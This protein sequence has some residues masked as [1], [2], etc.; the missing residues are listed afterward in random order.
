MDRQQIM[1]H[2]LEA[3]ER[4]DYKPQPPAWFGRLAALE[5]ASEREVREAVAQLEQRGGVVLTKRGRLQTPRQAGYV[6]GRFEGSGRG[7]GFVEGGGATLFVAARDRADALHGDLVLCRPTGEASGGRAAEGE[8]LRILERGPRQLLG[9]YAKEQGK[10]WFTP[11]EQRYGLDFAVLDNGGATPGDKVWFEVERWP[12]DRQPPAGAV[13]EV[14]GPAGEFDVNYR[15]LLLSHG[16][17]TEFPPAVLQRAQELEARGIPA[18]ELEGRRDLRGL[19]TFTIDGAGAKDFDDALSLEALPEGGF[20]LGVHIADVAHYVREGDPID[21]EARRRGTSVYFTDQVVPML[22]EVLSNQLCSLQPG[23]DRLT[24]SCLM[25]LDAQGN[26]TDYELVG[27]VIRSGA[28][29]IYGELNLLLEG[30][31]TAELAEKYRPVLE[32]ISTLSELCKKMTARRV[33][34][35]ALTFEVIEPQ[36]IVDPEGEPIDILAQPRGVTEHLVEE[37]MLAANRVVAGH[38]QRHRLPGIYRVHAAPPPD[39]LADLKVALEGFGLTLAV[40]EGKVAPEEL[41]RICREIEGS[42]H[43]QAVLGLM[44]RAMSKAAYREKNLGHYG[45]AEE[46]YCHFTSPIRRYPDLIVH[47]V[48]SLAERGDGRAI[49]R[50]AGRA[51]ELAT[52]AFA[53][54]ERAVRAERDIEDMYKCRYMAKFLG[55]TFEGVVTGVTGFGLFVTLKNTVEGLLHISALEDDDYAFD[56]QRRVLNGRRRGRSYR[57]GMPLS[58]TLVKSDPVSRRIDFILGGQGIANGARQA[59]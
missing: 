44:I 21:V 26:L 41:Q 27:S 53:C 8:V 17:V 13:R 7:F 40:R 55:E 12:K 22:P 43:E 23:E 42:P 11:D 20:V 38:L 39:K 24:R 31:A 49:A 15:G 6:V 14:L 51:G 28:R 33:Q 3:L 48:L 37:C 32:T 54:E 29:C 1:D 59:D 30:G 58:V 10:G 56:E 18:Q 25:A 34:K 5:G 9:T 50:L 57:L 2:I 36:I 35:G 47:R 52:A 46:D 19:Q 16:I 4:P 45:L